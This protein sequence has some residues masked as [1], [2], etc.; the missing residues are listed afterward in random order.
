[1]GLDVYPSFCRKNLWATQKALNG[2][3]V[4]GLAVLNLV[5]T[6]PVQLLGLGQALAQFICKMCKPLGLIVGLDQDMHMVRPKMSVCAHATNSSWPSPKRSRIARYKHVLAHECTQFLQ[7][8]PKTKMY[9]NY[10]NLLYVYSEK[11]MTQ[12]KM[13][14]LEFIFQF[15]QFLLLQKEVPK[16]DREFRTNISGL[17]Y[18]WA[19]LK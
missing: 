7:I 16:T 9:Q 2:V 6:Q 17:T 15:F 12:S 18:L 10:I 8:Q 3:H 19:L 4:A 14:I 11:A 13:K 1:M 5:R